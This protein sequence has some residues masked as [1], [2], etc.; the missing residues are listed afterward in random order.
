MD[1]DG[2]P[3]VLDFGLAKAM[4]HEGWDGARM[5]LTIDGRV[6]G[7]PAYMAPEQAAGRSEEIGPR[8]DVYSLGVILFRLLTDRYPH[9][10]SGSPVEV[11][12]RVM[13]QEV[14]RPREVSREI[15]RELEAL[16]L[17]S[18]ARAPM[19]R[20][21][22][23][24][25]LAQDIGSYLS[26]GVMTARPPGR[27][28]AATAWLK[29]HSV[30]LSVAALLVALLAVRG[31]GLL[32]GAELGAYDAF[33][34]LRPGAEPAAP[35]AIVGISE[36]DIRRLGHYPITDREMAELL[37]VLIEAGARAIGV[38]IYRD[39]EVPPGR[40]AL[41]RVLRENEQVCAVMQFGGR[42]GGID[43][44]PVLAGSAR[45]GFAD[46]AVDPDGVV[47][48]GLLFMNDAEATYQ[49]LG[50]CV[51]CTF[52]RGEGIAPAPD[53]EAPE[54]MQLGRTTFR[55]IEPDDGPYTG[56]DAGGYQFLLDYRGPKSFPTFSLTEALQGRLGDGAVRDAVVLVG[57]TAESVKDYISIPGRPEIYGVEMQAI[58]VDQL[59]RSALRG[60]GPMRGVPEWAEV[61]WV[62]AATLASGLIAFR[63]RSRPSFLAAG[64][65]GL[66]LLALVAYAL[67][68]AGWWVP[69]L[70]P[71]VGWAGAWML[72]GPYRPLQRRFA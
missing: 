31:A 16:L 17:R 8:S 46:Q 67:F 10:L 42:D 1:G 15:D 62:V 36:D 59:L 6:S 69:V 3:H 53:P 49:S 54:H 57:V 66:A 56:A 18:M 68:V 60:D 2:E 50:L 63:M 12:R 65:A 30:G 11:L 39:I 43:P 29:R 71:A 7:T 34:G 44:P 41:N 37:Q 32:Q 35:I 28:Y 5:E 20:Y 27:L 22:S 4:A 52:L 45:V 40:P 24:G 38:D 58:C 19:D 25:A 9:D 14:R 55:P 72:A 21:P 13:E 64:A 33:L 47:R 51:A 70:P 61:L 26:G 23:A 48:R